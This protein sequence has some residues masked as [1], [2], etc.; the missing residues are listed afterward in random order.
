MNYFGDYAA[1]YLFDAL[2]V[3]QVTK[4]VFHF[5]YDFFSFF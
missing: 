4:T 2:S 3:N 1:E 5:T